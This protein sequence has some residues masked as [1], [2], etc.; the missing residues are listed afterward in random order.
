MSIKKLFD[1]SRKGSR[2]YS[3]YSS[4]KETFEEVESSRNASLIKKDKDTFIP[5]IDYSN[6]E[7]FVKFGSAELFYSGAIDRIVDYYPYDGSEAEKNEFYNNLFDG[8]KYIFNNLYPRYNGFAV[9]GANGVTYTSKTS[10]GYGRPN[11]A[12][13]EYISFKGGPGSGSGGSL[14]VIGPSTLTDVLII[15][16]GRIAS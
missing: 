16:V 5:Q 10:D 9:L 2:N 7:N 1:K 12:S 14:T 13:T 4:D 6:P 11:A 3:D 15:F 8:E